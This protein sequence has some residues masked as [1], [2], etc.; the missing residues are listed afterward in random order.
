MNSTIRLE[1]A[2]RRIVSLVPSQTELLHDLGL[3]DEVVGITK[4]CIYPNQWFCGKHR[5]GGT[6]AVNFDKVSALKPDLIIGNKEENSLEDIK[7]LQTIAPVWMSDIYTLEDA[8]KMIEDLAEVTEKQEE[9]KAIISKINEEFDSLKV[10]ADSSEEKSALYYVWK[11]PNMVSGKN[12]FVDDMLSKCGLRN[13]TG[14][15]RY[16]EIDKLEE[17]PDY[18]LLSSEPF[19]F[20]DRHMD[21]FQARFPSSKI[22]LVDGEMFS[23]YGSRLIQAPTYFKQFLDQLA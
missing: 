5:V 21:E 9:G 20:K 10:V 7:L 22:V 8:L 11:D 15:E 16:P 6:K 4:F 1:E 13:A 3:E 19:P 23:W 2:P 17:N 12:T 14:V 18:V